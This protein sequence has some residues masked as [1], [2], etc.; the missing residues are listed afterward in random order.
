MKLS[1]LTLAACFGAIVFSRALERRADSIRLTWNLEP[2][3][4]PDGWL[5]A[6]YVGVSIGP[7]LYE[8]DHMITTLDLFLDTG[9]SGS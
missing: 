9:S 2:I 3:R 5:K 8:S 7:Q 6:W 4:T 1:L